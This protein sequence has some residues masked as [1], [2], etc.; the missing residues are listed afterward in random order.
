MSHLIP[1]KHCPK[2]YDRL[3]KSINTHQLD[4]REKNKNWVLKKV[5]NKK[6]HFYR[7]VVLSINIEYNV[8]KSPKPT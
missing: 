6:K 3:E 2:S 8:S 1:S 4:F 7:L 5:T